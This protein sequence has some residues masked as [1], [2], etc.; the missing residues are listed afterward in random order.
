MSAAS[1]ASVSRSTT[2]GSAMRSLEAE[3]LCSSRVRQLLTALTTPHCHG[4][5]ASLGSA[6]EQ[7]MAAAAAAA[8]AVVCPALAQSGAGVALWTGLGG[9]VSRS[10]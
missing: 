10:T 3:G 5:G 2:A 8:A 1:C 6:P 7:E 9:S 4:W